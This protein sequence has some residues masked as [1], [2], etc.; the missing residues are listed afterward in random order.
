MLVIHVNLQLLYIFDRR[1]L[2]VCN[3]HS[4]EHS[5]EKRP[6]NKLLLE[7]DGHTDPNTI[8]KYF[9]KTITQQNYTV[10]LR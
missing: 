6:S 5:V 4:E 7:N 2:R 1:P 10:K 9:T 8:W 3:D